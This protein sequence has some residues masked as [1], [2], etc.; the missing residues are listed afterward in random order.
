MV[1]KQF[2]CSNSM[3]I[4]SVLK[5]LEVDTSESIQEIKKQLKDE[6]EIPNLKFLLFLKSNKKWYKLENTKQLLDDFPIDGR[7]LQ[8]DIKRFVSLEK[9]VKLQESLKITSVS[10]FPYGILQVENTPSDQTRK[11]LVEAAQE[12]IDDALRDPSNVSFSIPSRSGDNIGFDEESEL[13]LLGKQRTERQFRN[14]SSVKSVQQLSTLMRIL[15][16]V[17]LRDIHSTKRDLFYQDVNIFEAQT[18]SD[19]LIEDLGALLGVSRSSLNVTASS[20]GVVVGHIDFTEKGDFIDCRKM[21]S[22]KSITP[23]IDDIEKLQ[24]D[25]EFVLVVEKDA[26][27]N[28]LAEDQFYD[29][30]PSIIIT[31]KGQPD[32]ATR[33][34]LKKID[35][36]L[37]IP[38]LAIMDADVYGFEILRVYS[39]GSKA[40]SFESSNLAVPNIKWL[41]L[42]PTD[43]DESSGFGIPRSVLLDA[44]KN[45]EDRLKL[46]LEEEFVKRKPAWRD[47]IQKLIDLKKKAEIQALNAQ[48]PQYITNHYLPMKLESGDFI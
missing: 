31:A 11:I 25:A 48:D 43:L 41:G 16:E 7:G 45:D 10:S 46:L 32:M 18:T 9:I 15:H 37:K 20:K 30:V 35:D 5:T 6:F 39:V 47:Q 26:I 44:K 17:L 14:L 38:I 42:L 33:M 8:L 1:V 36:E 13:V 19:N 23:N 22:G 29:Y 24:S 34:F 40:L 3:K 4:P 21:G 12:F 27:F 2:L 28:R